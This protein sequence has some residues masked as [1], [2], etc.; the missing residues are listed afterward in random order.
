MVYNPMCE[1]INMSDII[2]TS[3]DIVHIFDLLKL[4]W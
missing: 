3:I 4:L 2:N 1:L